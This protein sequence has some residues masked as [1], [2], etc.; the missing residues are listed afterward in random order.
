MTSG[1]IK[2]MINVTKMINEMSDVNREKINCYRKKLN[3]SSGWMKK[4]L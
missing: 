1:E 2:E 4:I 3:F